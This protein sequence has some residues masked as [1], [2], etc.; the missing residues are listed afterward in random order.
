MSPDHRLL[1][2]LVGVAPIAQ[3][4]HGQPEDAVAMTTDQRAERLPTAFL[5]S[6]GERLVGL[7]PGPGERGF[8]R[9]A[10]SSCAGKLQW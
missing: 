2:D 1:G 7:R 3:H 5:R 9:T 10:T 8:H 4:P 6:P